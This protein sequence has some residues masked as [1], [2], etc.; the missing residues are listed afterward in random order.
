MKFRY[1]TP[2]AP[3]LALMLASCGGGDITVK[4][5]LNETFVVKKSA[6]NEG[7]YNWTKRLESLEGL[8]DVTSELQQN[9]EDNYNRCASG[10][11]GADKCASI[12]L[13][14]NSHLD[15]GDTEATIA[16]IQ[17][18]QGIKGSVKVVTYRPI[19][20]DVNNDKRAM[21]YTTV[22]C[23]SNK[24][25]EESNQLLKAMNFKAS[26]R[27]TPAGVSKAVH[28]LG[29]KVCQQYAFSDTVAFGYNDRPKT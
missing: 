12:W 29:A 21:G 15:L 13:R 27:F 23:L 19:F 18:Y 28:E 2:L 25:S 14:D 4:T 1:F 10:R 5:D 20:T 26:Q 8:R 7:S 17:K 9:R 24:V 16:L 22:T 6:V 3:A 11:L